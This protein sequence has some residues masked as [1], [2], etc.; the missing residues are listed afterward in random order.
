VNDG[1]YPLAPELREGN[2]QH[3]SDGE[4]VWIVQ[5]GIPRYAGLGR[6]RRGEPDVL[7]VSQIGAGRTE[8]RR[9]HRTDE[10]LVAGKVQVY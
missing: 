9:G 3:L 5:N 2:T 6:S 8:A 4:I 7:L 1:L 10:Q